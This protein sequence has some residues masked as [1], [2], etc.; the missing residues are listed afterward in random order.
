MLGLALAS[1]GLVLAIAG[2]LT[3]GAELAISRETAPNL[4]SP[5]LRLTRRLDRD[6]STRSP[7]R[8]PITKPFAAKTSPTYWRRYILFRYSSTIQYVRDRITNAWTVITILEATACLTVDAVLTLE[9]NS[10]PSQPS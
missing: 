9:A 5:R 4:F 8:I 6:P 10:A 3:L 1:S 2:S 7:P